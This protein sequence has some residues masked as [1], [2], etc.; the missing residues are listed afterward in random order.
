M[1]SS[2]F[3]GGMMPRYSPKREELEAQRLSKDFLKNGANGAEVARQRGTTRQ[4]E[5][6]KLRRKPVQD[7]LQ[8]LIDKYIPDDLV[9]KQHSALL[10]CGK[11][12]GVKAGVDMAYK[13]KGYY[14][15]GKGGVNVSTII[16]NL[17]N[18]HQLL[19]KAETES[20]PHE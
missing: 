6:M 17:G 16:V 5:N 8:K 11:T 7:K 4:N 15:N 12:E 1:G 13:L 18:R 3:I 19:S 14:P 9:L 10:I 2:F 20:F